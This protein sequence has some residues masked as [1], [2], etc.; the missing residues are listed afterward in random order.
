[1]AER[2]RN[3]AERRLARRIYIARRLPIRI[4]LGL[5]GS[6]RAGARPAPAHSRAFDEDI[7]AQRLT[8]YSESP[9]H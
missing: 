6:R 5:S 1:M 9:A 2:A 8:T 3:V 4:R 7:N